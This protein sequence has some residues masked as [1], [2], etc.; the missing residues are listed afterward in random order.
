M[1]GASIDQASALALVRTASDPTPNR[2]LRSR[3]TSFPVI[4]PIDPVMVPGLA[5]M[6]SAPIDT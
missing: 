2:S 3:T 5:T 4:T 6:A 1:K